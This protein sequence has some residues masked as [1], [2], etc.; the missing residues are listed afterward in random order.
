MASLFFRFEWM[1]FPAN[2]YMMQVLLQTKRPNRRQKGDMNL[3]WEKSER[4]RMRCD[5]FWLRLECSPKLVSESIRIN[6]LAHK[7]I[8]KGLS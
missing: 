1:N 6:L 2:E 3:I 4:C 7:M 8:A 5:K